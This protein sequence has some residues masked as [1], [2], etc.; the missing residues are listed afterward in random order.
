MTARTLNWGS[1]VHD[2]RLAPYIQQVATM[3]RDLCHASRA[4][5]PKL[6]PAERFIC[7]NGRYTLHDDLR[8]EE[9]LG[10]GH[11]VCLDIHHGP[12]H[13]YIHSANHTPTPVLNA[14]ESGK[15]VKYHAR[16]GIH[17]ATHREGWIY[18]IQEGG[19]R[20]AI[21]QVG[22]WIGDYVYRQAVTSAGSGCMA[23]LDAEKVLDEND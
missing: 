21:D 22:R 17:P 11:H 20:Q 18:W 12:G 3:S 8:R 13:H 2:P 15:P 7:P 14:Q 4:A 5:D 10:L 6:H 9:E 23:A 19:V 1:G 16:W